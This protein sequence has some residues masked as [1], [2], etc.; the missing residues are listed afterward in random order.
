MDD[1]VGKPEDEEADAG[2]AGRGRP[3]KHV[4]A[5]DRGL[6]V[7][8]AIATND[9]GTISDISDLTSLPRSTV[10]RV[11]QTLEDLGYVRRDHH[12]PVFRLTSRVR[13]LTANIGHGNLLSELA[14]P[15]LQRLVREVLWPSSLA[16]FDHD[17]MLIIDTTHHLSP[18]SIHRNAIGTRLPLLTTAMGRAHLCFCSDA[19]LEA[20]FVNL[21]ARHDA[22]TLDYHRRHILALRKQAAR[23]GYAYSNGDTDPRFLSFALPI[24][25]G[26]RVVAATNLIFFRKS[27][28]LDHALEIYLAPLARAVAEIEALISAGPVEL[29]T[30]SPGAGAPDSRQ[31]ARL[32]S[33]RTMSP[34]RLP[35]D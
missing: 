24:R 28:K 20:I 7:L 29:D 31:R 4:R 1:R 19:E 26:G 11:V 13:F 30:P 17:A 9:H 12:R 15:V 18:H 14:A 34:A 33:I 32:P 21:A 8:N 5:L 2:R 10:Y 27:M 25:R 23:I 3:Y 22:A 35:P 16:V 6:S